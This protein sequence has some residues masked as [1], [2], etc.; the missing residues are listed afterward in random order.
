M[1]LIGIGLVSLG[2]L[3]SALP[4]SMSWRICGWIVWTTNLGYTFEMVPLIVKMAAIF[5]LMSAAERMERVVVTRRQLFG[6]VF[7]ISF[8]MVVFLIVWTL[9]DPSQH[10][11]EYQ[12]IPREDGD[13]FVVEFSCY[14]GSSSKTWSSLSLCS[15]FLRSSTRSRCG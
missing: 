13:E 11:A 4:S 9:V 3:F 10:M 15:S 5:R 6:A 14:C 12:D 2:S 8:I 1:L 7:G